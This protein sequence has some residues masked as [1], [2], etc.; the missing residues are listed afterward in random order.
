MP[1]A[2]D[3][4]RRST[5][6]FD[7]SDRSLCADLAGQAGENV[8]IEAARIIFFHRSLLVL[9][10]T[11]IAARAPPAGYRLGRPV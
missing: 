2:S 1:A 7:C 5:G 4:F 6:H 11:T 10:S 9:C 8:S 3:L